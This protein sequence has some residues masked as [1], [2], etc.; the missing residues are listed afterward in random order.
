M[1]PAIQNLSIQL[2]DAATRTTASVVADR[3]RVVKAKRKDAEI[4]AELEELVSEL[5][6]DKA[7]LVHIGQALDEQ[8]VS[9]RLSGEDV[10][11]IT[12]N[13]LPV[14]SQLLESGAAGQGDAAKKAKATQDMMGVLKPILS[15][16][17]VNVLQLLGFNFKRAVGEPLTDLLAQLIMS[18]ARQDPT[19]QAEV[20]RLSLE[21][22]I[23]LLRVTQDPDAFDRLVRARAVLHE[24]SA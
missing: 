11:Y 20:Q 16:E 7:E 9:Q 14:I 1:D 4:I 22:Q 17:T 13:V 3:I 12:R 23:E 15:A 2:A 10:A 5:V 19:D 8:L 18:K 6:R 21:A 24:P